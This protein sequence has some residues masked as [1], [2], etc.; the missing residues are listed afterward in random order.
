MLKELPDGGDKTYAEL[1]GKRL[2]L[3]AM[4]GKEKSIGMLLDRTDGKVAEEWKGEVEHTGVVGSIELKGKD[5]R[6]VVAMWKQ[7]LKGEVKRRNA[8]RTEDE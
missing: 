1:V 8:T 2:I 6:E 5:N 3:N 7:F 4:S